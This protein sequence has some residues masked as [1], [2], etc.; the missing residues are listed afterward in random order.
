MGPP[1][2]TTAASDA[3]PF[4]FDGDR[5]GVLLVHGFTGTPFEMRL[6]GEALA[7]R[8]Y[9]VVGPLLAGHGGSAEELAATR[10]PDWYAT[11]ERAFDELRA[12]TDRV[13]VVGL[14]LGGLLSLEL[15]R[16]RRAQ[17]AAVGCMA[18]PLWIKPWMMRGVRR[19]ARSWLL[20][21]LV[22]PKWGGSDI[23]DAE[24]RRKNPGTPGM[25]VPALESLFDFMDHVHRHLGEVERPA[26]VAHA[27]N[28][29]TA[30]V[31]CM[32]VVVDRV[33]GPVDQLVLERSAHIIT[34]DVER[35][36]LFERLGRFLAPHL[37]S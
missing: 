7:R 27:K 9:S 32:R 12:R 33:K 24:M 5:R 6:C 20:K 18:A 3:G 16:R 14:S 19:A 26:F 8:G 31:D 15:A 29:H 25:P 22:I 21:N 23:V 11:V 30:P 28:D 36:V 13:A 2:T 17:L 34:L 10:W 37:E 35:E 4:R 1:A